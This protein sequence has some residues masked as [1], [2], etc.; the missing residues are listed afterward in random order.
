MYSLRQDQVL[1]DSALMAPICV[2]AAAL[3]LTLTTTGNLTAAPSTAGNGAPA[4]SGAGVQATPKIAPA[5]KAVQPAK[6]QAKKKDGARKKRRLRPAPPPPTAKLPSAGAAPIQRI[7]PLVAELWKRPVRLEGTRIHQTEIVLT[8]Q[9]GGRDVTRDELTLILAAHR[10]YLFPHHHRHHGPVVVL[11]RDPNW[12]PEPPRFT[13]IITLPPERFAAVWGKIARAVAARN[14]RA[15]AQAPPVVA[16]PSPR[17]GKIFLRAPTP[18]DLTALEKI[19]D[20]EKEAID[21]NRPRLYTHI[22]NRLLAEA[23]RDK[24]IAQLS[25]G[26]QRRVR[27]IVAA[28]GNRLLFRAPP[29]VGDKVRELLIKLDR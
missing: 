14:D 2:A 28:R 4:T 11:T 22:A 15:G 6:A 19:A 29:D 20:V 26:E 21:P 24:V 27:M 16:V 23:L 3:A 8:S 18:Q 12:Y 1:R 13:G 25:D 7:Q 17:T 9:L 5:E 10:V